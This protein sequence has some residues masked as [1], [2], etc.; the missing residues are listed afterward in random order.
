VASAPTDSSN[1][2][3]PATAQRGTIADTDTTPALRRKKSRLEMGMV[4]LL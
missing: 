4:G 2:L 3:A 1:I